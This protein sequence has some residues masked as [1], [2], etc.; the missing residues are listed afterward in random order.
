ME[1]VLLHLQV[2]S[3]SLRVQPLPSMTLYILKELSEAQD[4]GQKNLQPVYS[5]L[6]FFPLNVSDA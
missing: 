6:M 5:C 1:D 2:C 3:Q 4:L